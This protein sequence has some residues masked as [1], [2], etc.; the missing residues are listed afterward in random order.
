MEKRDG[1]HKGIPVKRHVFNRFVGIFSIQTSPISKKND[2][3]NR[4]MF[5]WKY[6]WAREK[7]VKLPSLMGSTLNSRIN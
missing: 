1:V 7:E 5:G 4:E 2:I 3:K 6:Q